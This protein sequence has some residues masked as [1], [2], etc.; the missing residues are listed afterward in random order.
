M[1]VGVDFSIKST[2]VT[3]IT[4][5]GNY[6]FYTF[7]RKSVAK[8]DFF[9]TLQNSGVNVISLPDEAPL[10]K[11]ANLTD[12]ERSSI[13]DGLMLTESIVQTLSTHNFDENSH[14]AIEGFSFASTGNRLAQISGYQWL[15]R[16]KLMEALKINANQL[17]FYSPMTIK[18]TAGKG[19]YKK[20]EMIAAFINSD[21]NCKFARRLRE[22]PAEFQNKKGQWL[23]PL[24]DLVDSYWIAK[25]L[26]K[27]LSTK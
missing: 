7:A 16:A 1:I 10:P 4:N 27:T 15:L 25:T 18:A 9:L 14:V 19:N 2:A 8:E 6:Y 5:L 23:K 21:A 26:E 11:T 13:V 20:E 17:S 3:V 22:A 12:K 24:D